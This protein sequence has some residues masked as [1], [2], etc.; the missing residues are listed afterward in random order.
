MIFIIITCMCIAGCAYAAL[1][2]APPTEVLGNM[3]RV[4]FFHV[5]VAWVSVIAFMYAGV[6]S[7]ADLRKI[8]TGIDDLK[9]QAY[10]ATLIGIVFSML[11]LLTGAIWAKV[12]WNSFW[13]WD[14]RQ[15]TIV[16]LLLVY[17]AYLS[18]FKAIKNESKRRRIGA[19]YLILAMVTVPL[20]VFILPRMADTL[21]PD[22]ISNKNNYTAIDSRIRVILYASVCAYTMLFTV[23]LR[24][25]NKTHS[26]ER[27]LEELY[28]N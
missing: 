23:I 8:N 28:E 11:A 1:L 18:L 14:P 6:M 21:H 19:V 3:S 22:I 7:I 24:L 20:F 16:F 5:P 4:L 12:N 15:K 2:I 9:N 10:H 13:N 25:L 17:I 27:E 26:L